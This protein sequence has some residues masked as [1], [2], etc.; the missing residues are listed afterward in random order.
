MNNR[1]LVAILGC[2]GFVA[3]IGILFNVHNKNAAPV[4]TNFFAHQRIHSYE[5]LPVG[6]YQYYDVWSFGSAD[7]YHDDLMTVVMQVNITAKDGVHHTLSATEV[8]GRWIPVT[9]PRHAHIPGQNIH[10]SVPDIFT[11]LL[12]VTLTK[13][14]LKQ[15]AVYYPFTGGPQQKENP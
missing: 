12:E 6:I 3:C 7:G 10:S 1:T 11:G 9:L 15:I 5:D 8:D 14:G 13:E 4:H 2:C